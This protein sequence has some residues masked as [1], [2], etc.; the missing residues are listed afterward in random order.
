MN[1][2]YI[3][4]F[5]ALGLKVVDYHLKSYIA[6]N[7]NKEFKLYELFGDDTPIDGTTTSEYIS[8]EFISNQPM[9]NYIRMLY[10]HPEFSQRFIDFFNPL[11]L[12]QM[13]IKLLEVKAYFY[14]LSKGNISLIV[15]PKSPLT[16]TMLSN[17]D[18]LVTLMNS[19]FKS[20]GAKEIKLINDV[21]EQDVRFF[22]F[23][24]YI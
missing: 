12:E 13:S 11:I 17:M 15:I 9:T 4:R 20:W 16:L 14:N 7:A 21:N 3:L 18:S 19:F 23:V 24:I 5:N 8:D 22:H 2:K 10:V 1:T 6:D